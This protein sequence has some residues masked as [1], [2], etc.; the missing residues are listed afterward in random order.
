MQSFSLSCAGPRR[1]ERPDDRPRGLARSDLT[2]PWTDPG[3][4]ALEVTDLG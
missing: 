1:R 4:L 3:L 2:G